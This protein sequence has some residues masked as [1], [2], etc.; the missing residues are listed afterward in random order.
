LDKES[1]ETLINL[2]HVGIALYDGKAS[3]NIYYVGYSSG[4]IAH[5]LKC[6]LPIVVNKL[7]VI[8]ELVENY[9]CGVVVSNPQDIRKALIEI[10]LNYDIFSANAHRAYDNCLNPEIYIDFILL[11]LFSIDRHSS[12]S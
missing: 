7:P 11:K 2:C 10:N 6:G 8:K 9:K 5:Y 3:E 1:Y 12:S 4:K